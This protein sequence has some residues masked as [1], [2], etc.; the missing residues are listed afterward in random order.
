MSSLCKS[1]FFQIHWVSRIR[2]FLTIPAAE[3]IVHSIVTS[4]L[5]YCNGALAGLP[6]S[7]IA[8][9]QSAQN[10]DVCLISL[11]TKRDHFMPILIELHWLPVHQRIMFKILVITYKAINVLA[12]SYITNLISTHT[13]TSLYAPQPNFN[14]PSLAT[15]P[16]P[17]KPGCS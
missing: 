5:D 13:P 17:M 3:S 15:R 8:K 14:C 10:S 11:T 6:D 1:A 4:Q 7:D 12:P 2:K 9:L 16:P